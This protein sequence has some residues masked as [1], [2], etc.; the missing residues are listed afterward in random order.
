MRMFVQISTWLTLAV[1]SMS[2]SCTPTETNV[3]IISPGPIKLQ[4]YDWQQ[5][6]VR[7]AWPQADREQLAGSV[8]Q[9]VDRNL[10][11]KGYEKQTGAAD[12]QVAAAL[13]LQ[14][15]PTK[16]LPGSRYDWPSGVFIFDYEQYYRK[17]L[18]LTLE[19]TESAEN[20]I[21]YRSTTVT[22]IDTN[23]TFDRTEPDVDNLVNESLE[24]LPPSTAN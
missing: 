2:A 9:Q 21:I 8:R 22:V 7:I 18:E 14:D 16:G 24:E 10:T 1:L 23:P 19:L 6:P 4:T 20:K 5:D 12:F 15:R 17:P 13:E 3:N 11:A